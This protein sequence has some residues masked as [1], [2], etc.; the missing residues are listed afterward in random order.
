[1]LIGLLELI[2]LCGKNVE[3]IGLGESFQHFCSTLDGVR[4]KHGVDSGN[5]KQKSLTSLQQH[6]VLLIKH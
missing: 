4:Q 1:M 2:D 5:S 3:N 6:E